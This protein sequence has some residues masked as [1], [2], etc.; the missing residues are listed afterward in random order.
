M[1]TVYGRENDFMGLHTMQ[2]LPGMAAQPWCTSFQPLMYS[3]PQEEH[4]YLEG[5]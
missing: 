4:P 1:L 5:G 3:L 2:S